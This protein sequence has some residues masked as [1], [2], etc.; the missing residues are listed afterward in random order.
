MLARSAVETWERL[1]EN[2]DP[3]TLKKL[4]VAKRLARLA[5]R[6]PH[7]WLPGTAITMAF[8]NLPEPKLWCWWIRQ[9]QLGQRLFGA[10]LPN[11]DRTKTTVTANQQRKY[12]EKGLGM[13]SLAGTYGG[14]KPGKEGARGAV[15]ISLD[16]GLVPAK[17]CAFTRPDALYGMRFVLGMLGDNVERHDCK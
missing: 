8:D 11:M 7:W 12:W 1:L 6:A 3:T 5:E 17:A 14:D 9:L 16:L 4:A 10:H 13:S 15:V 2:G